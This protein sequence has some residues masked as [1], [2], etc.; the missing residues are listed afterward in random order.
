MRS[1]LA[2]WGL[3][4]PRKP[5]T[6]DEETD[7]MPIHPANWPSLIAFLGCETQWRVSGTM[8]GLF[9]LGLDYSAVDVIARLESWSKDIWEN[10]RVMEA[11]ALPVLNEVEQ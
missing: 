5:Q 1:D 10:V 11:A 9:W 8:A 7:R 2:A 6:R 4:I 3:Q